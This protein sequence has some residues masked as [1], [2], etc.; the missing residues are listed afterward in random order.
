MYN[1][2]FDG[3]L[4]KN[5]IDKVRF[6]AIDDEA[7]MGLEN[8]TYVNLMKIALGNSD[9]IIKGSE[10]IPA[11][12]EEYINTLEKPVL[13]YHN[14]ENFSQAYLDFYSEKVLK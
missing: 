1:Q 8:P 5:T 14:M 11:E 7:I 3:E 4:A 13:N 6:D 12:L 9:A 10:E 2:G